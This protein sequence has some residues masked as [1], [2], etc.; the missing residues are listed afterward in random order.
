MRHSHQTCDLCGDRK[1]GN[2]D[3]ARL[4]WAS[5]NV[6]IETPRAHDFVVT[7][8]LDICRSCWGKVKGPP[9]DVLLA[10]LVE[11]LS[12]EESKARGWS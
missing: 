11:K 10:K 9:N 1:P 3:E 4:G 8:A 6:E 12:E 5:L 7:A 2:R